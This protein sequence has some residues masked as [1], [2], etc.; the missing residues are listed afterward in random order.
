MYKIFENEYT[1][2]RSMRIFSSPQCP[3]RPAL[4]PTQYPTQWIPGVPFLWQNSWGVN[5][6]IHF[7]LLLRSRIVKLYLHS[8]IYLHGVVLN[9]LST[10][11]TLPYITVPSTRASPIRSENSPELFLPDLIFIGQKDLWRTSEYHWMVGIRKDPLYNGSFLR[12]AVKYAQ[13]FR[14]IIS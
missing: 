14:I 3:D 8:P 11:T 9:Y 10:G 12:Q 5:L 13:M 1:S 6:S 4:G 2:G 7:H